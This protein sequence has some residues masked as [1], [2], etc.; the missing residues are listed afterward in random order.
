V[1]SIRV[2]ETIPEEEHEIPPAHDDTAT[3]E[4]PAEPAIHS[5]EAK[6]Q[7][8]PVQISLQ[9]DK[10]R[11]LVIGGGIALLI[12]G[13]F[14]IGLIRNQQ[15][16]KKEVTRLSGGSTNSQQSQS[17]DQAEAEQLKGE[18]GKYL[19]LPADEIPTVATVADANKVKDQSFFVNAQ[20]GDKVL[21][22]A[23]SGKAILYRP[24]TKKIIEVA[25][26]NVNQP[27]S[28]NPGTTQTSP[29]SN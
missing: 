22:F 17:K 19:E 15:N 6:A 10:K 20:N 8:A 9:I 28:S 2:K 1:P 5:N 13:I 12:A 21:L 24:S 14:I 26:I 4:Q 29:K 3:A 18:I 23:K 7:S 11:L 27:Q 25:P 16:L